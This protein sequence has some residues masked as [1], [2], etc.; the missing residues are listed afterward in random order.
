MK[1]RKKIFSGHAKG[2][3]LMEFALITPLMLVLLL[4][5]IEFGFFFF[6]YSSVNSAAREASRFGSAA[7]NSEAN[8]PYYQYCQGIRDAAKRIGLYSGVQ[9]AQISVG[10]DQGPDTTT[11][12]THCPVG[13][14]VTSDPAVLGDRIVV[15]I[16]VQYTPISSII[17]MPPIT[18][19]ALSART[20]VTGMELQGTSVPTRTVQ[21]SRTATQTIPALNSPTP[22]MTG[23]IPDTPTP[24]RTGTQP[25]PENSPEGCQTPLELGGCE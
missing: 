6:V 19:R 14:G 22:T 16:V 18:I 21:N 7:G 11:D 4:F 12:W 13:A 25:T 8:V 5:V 24:T 20:I 10:L 17:G 2:Q 9:D 3:G 1:A 15:R 23:V